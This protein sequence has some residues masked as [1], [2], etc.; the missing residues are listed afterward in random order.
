MERGSIFGKGAIIKPRLFALLQFTFALLAIGAMAAGCGDD[1]AATPG[2][3]ETAEPT[4]TE[5]AT[6]ISGATAE[7]FRQFTSSGKGYSIS[8]PETWSIEEG[9]FSSGDISGDGFLAPEPENDFFANVNVLCEPIPEGTTTDEYYEAALE[10]LRSQ[11]VDAQEVDE[12]TVG[13]S[14]GRLLYYTSS[15]QEQTLDF[16]QVATAQGACG[17]VI[18]LTTAEGSRSEYLDEFIEMVASFQPD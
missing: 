17:W 1:E 9:A 6:S 4:I 8:Y 7:G 3:G 13:G 15:F 5:T 2:G 11:G 10:S 14:T 18:T 16:A 12:I